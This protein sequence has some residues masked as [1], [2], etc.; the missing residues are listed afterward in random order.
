MDEL[1]Q[2]LNEYT[3]AIKKG[4]WNSLSLEEIS[5]AYEKIQVAKEKY[6]D[7]NDKSSYSETLFYTK[8]IT[9]VKN[10]IE[11]RMEVDTTTRRMDD[12]GRLVFPKQFR[13]LLGNGNTEL[14]GKQ[15]EIKLIY[16][17]KRNQFGCQ[18]FCI[19]LEDEK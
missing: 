16:D 11:A 13:R 10:Y 19:D 6:L 17:E 9:F 7:S 5:Q 2:L 8:L 18:V 3:N 12:L 15:F 4:D 1:L 14:D